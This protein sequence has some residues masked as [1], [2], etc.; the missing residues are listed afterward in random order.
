M[1]CTSQPWTGGFQSTGDGGKKPSS[2]LINQIIMN[3][4]RKDSK[5]IQHPSLFIYCVFELL[6]SLAIYSWPQSPH[7]LRTLVLDN[8]VRCPLKILSI[9]LGGLA[10]TAVVLDTGEPT[11]RT[12]SSAA[13]ITWALSSDVPRDA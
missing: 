4:S 9:S 6:D 8:E 3:A 5:P 13:S 1:S 2:T 10:S 7:F 12:P 11:A